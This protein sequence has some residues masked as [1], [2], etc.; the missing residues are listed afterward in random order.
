MAAFFHINGLRQ[1]KL[2]SVSFQGLGPAVTAG[3]ADPRL[4]IAVLWRISPNC[5][6]GVHWT[7]SGVATRIP[8]D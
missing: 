3:S 6:P 4:R 8:P 1:Q 2:S 7:V 5:R